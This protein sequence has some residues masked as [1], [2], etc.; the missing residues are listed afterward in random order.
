LPG[1]LNYTAWR[2]AMMVLQWAFQARR[3][4]FDSRP[5]H[6][7]PVLAFTARPSTWPTRVRFPSGSLNATKWWNLVDT[8]QSECR[9]LEAWEFDSPLRHFVFA[10]A[11]GA[12][13]GFISPTSPVRYRD[14]QPC[15]WASAQWSFMCSAGRVRPPDPPS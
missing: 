7:G 13:L 5:R 12:Q 3:H 4:G 10:G 8:R 2:G 14:L 15:G 11:A 1:A 9:A 6:F